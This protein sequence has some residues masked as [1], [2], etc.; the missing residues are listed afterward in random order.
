MSVPLWVT[1]L[2][3]AF[4]QAAGEPEPFPR[5]LRRPIARALQMTVVSLPGLGVD[6][7]RDWLQEHHIGCPCQTGDRALRACLAAHGGWGY[8]FL[9]GTDPEDEQR[10]SLAHELAHFLRHYWQP[11]QQALRQ[12]GP[13]VLHVF[14]GLRPPNHAERLHALLA[15]V[16]VGFHWHLME[17][18][19]N[20][21]LAGAEA[22]ADRLAWELLAPA[23]EIAQRAAAGRVTVRDFLVSEFG[24]PATQAASY[25]Q[26]LAPQTP[27]DPLLRRLGFVS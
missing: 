16:P 26:H 2:A 7:V 9:D 13:G 3:A 1:D 27:T 10:F 17:R 21:T 8:V 4:W 6:K 25:A 11:R 24:L 12:L 19:P 23:E 15:K 20:D 18:G 14:D 5:H 22:E